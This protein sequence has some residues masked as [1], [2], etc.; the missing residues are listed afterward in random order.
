MTEKKTVALI[1]TLVAR[2]TKVQVKKIGDTLTIMETEALV[3]TSS[4]P[5]IKMKSRRQSTQ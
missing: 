2:L 1:Y 3:E 5:V 4:D